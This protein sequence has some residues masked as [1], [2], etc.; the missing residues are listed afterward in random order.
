MWKIRSAESECRSIA[1][2]MEHAEYGKMWSAGV[3]LKKWKMLSVENEECRNIAQEVENAEYG[4]AIR[5]P[6]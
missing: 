3:L 6:N 4:N 1:Q 2:E 5:A